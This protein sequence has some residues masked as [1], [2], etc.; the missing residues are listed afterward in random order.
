MKILL[1]EDEPAIAGVVARGLGQAGFAVTIASNA[2]DGF[3][4]AEEE[5]WDILLLDWMLPGRNGIEICRAL[6]AKRDRTPILILTARDAVPDRVLGLESGADDYLPKPFAFEELVARVR[7]L[8]RRDAAHKSQTVFLRDLEIDLLHRTI[9]RNG[10]DISLSPREWTLLEALIRN[11]G[12]PLTRDKILTHIWD[13]EGRTG[14]N[15]VDVYITSLRRK[16]DSDT[17]SRLIHT[18]HG[19][20]YVL[21]RP[22]VADATQEG[23]EG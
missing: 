22:G 17:E 4:L 8:L 3:R 9:K 2:D 6:R 12:R 18:V 20:G 16:V 11:E 21:R 19:V 13:D 14:S 1:V 5:D 15:T 7:A 10:T 23:I